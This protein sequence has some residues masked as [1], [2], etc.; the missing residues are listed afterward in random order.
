M[1]ADPTDEY[2]LPEYAKV[3]DAYGKFTDDIQ[4]RQDCI[5]LCTGQTRNRIRSQQDGIW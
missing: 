4:K 2:D 5:C 3:M 1:A